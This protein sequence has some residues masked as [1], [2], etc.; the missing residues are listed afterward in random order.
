VRQGEIVIPGPLRSFMRMAGLSQQLAPDDVLPELARNIYA[1]GFSPSGETEFLA[2]LQRYVRQARDIQSFATSTGELR[3]A[4]CDDARGLL[5]VL[6][7]RISGACGQKDLSLV[8][9]DPDNAFLT[10]DSGFPLTRLEESLQT[11]QPFVYPYAPSSVPV[12]LRAGDWTSISNWHSAKGQDLLDTLLHDPRVARLYWALSKMDPETRVSLQRSQGL[13]NLL[14]YASALDFYGTQIS[15]RSRRV[16]VPGGAAAEIGWKDLVGVSPA[17]PGEFVLRLLS[18]DRGWLAAYYDTLARVDQQQQAHLTHGSRLGDLYSALRDQGFSTNAAGAAFRKGSD[19][20][21][22]FTRQQWQPDGQPRIPGNIDVWKQ[23]LGKRGRHV[24]HP[25]QLLEAMVAASRVETNKG[26]LQIYLTL[27][28][29]ADNPAREKSLS[30]DT[31]LLMAGNYA[32]FSAWYPIFSEFPQLGDESI[33]LFI[34][35][36][37]SLDKISD[38]ELRGNALG[39]MQANVGLWQILA[40]QGEIPANQLASSWHAIIDPLNKVTSSGELFN[41]GEL[42]LGQLTLAATGKTSCPQNDLIDLLA[43]PPQQ[44]VEGKRVRAVLARRMQLVLDDQRLTSL[45][46]LAELG[47]GIDAMSHGGAS[48][49]KLLALAGTLREFELPRPIFSEQ[50]KLDWAPGSAS[51][52][53]TEVQVRSSLA[54][55]I[56]QTGKLDA[57]RGLLTPFLR[58]TLVG[59]NYAYYEPPGSQ[60]LHINPLFVRAHDFSSQTVQ[61]EKYVWQAPTLFGQGAS[62]GGGAYLVGSLADLPYVLA[63]TE[64]NLIAPENVQ[65]LIWE[66]ITPSILAGATLSRWWNITPREMHAVALYQR[67]GE[68]LLNDSAG[69]PKLRDKVLTILSGRLSPQ[70]LQRVEAAR[71]PKDMADVIAVLAPSDTFF[72]AAEFRQRFPQDIAAAGQTNQSLDQITRQYPDEVSLERISRDFGVPHPT[73]AQTYSR[74]L[75]NVRTFPAFAGYSYRLFGESWDSG[76]LYWARFA[77]ERGEAP[78]T[79]NLMAPQLTRMMISKIFASDVEDSPS[80][81]RAMR[82]TGDELQHRAAAVIPT[83]GSGSQ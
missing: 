9:L 61:G 25:E 82:E 56:Q 66:E 17:S 29:L 47:E 69:N 64:Q 46:T 65:A 23:I 58:D 21:I 74:E 22:L 83:V 53:H 3:V 4:N 32:Q 60:V 11:G 7:Y 63:A 42:S 40:R 76:N 38:L 31:M 57:A 75:I 54:K 50:E 44:S 16:L 67:A 19:L 35:T 43:G 52:R 12:L 34:Q 2:L 6:G 72:L 36:A 27:S 37:A 62:A 13:Y 24:N 41:A 81:V 33:S 49:E 68:E 51:P 28:A 1:D 48:S 71:Q 15:I 80:L 26:P 18:Q 79:L 73:L 78:E 77:D 10:I 14:P 59:L 30:P 5:Q 8:T 39:I 45:D 20:L 55:L 70:Q